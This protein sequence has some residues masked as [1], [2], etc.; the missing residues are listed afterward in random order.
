MLRAQALTLGICT[1]LIYLGY[2]LMTRQDPTSSENP[3]KSLT[4]I[5]IGLI[6][7]LIASIPLT[8]TLSRLFVESLMKIFLPAHHY[9]PPPLYSLPEKY[10]KEK[11]TEEA[12][13][14]YRKI[15][16]YHPTEL[17]A[18]LALIKIYHS[19]N[20]PQDAETML[21]QARKHISQPDAL[22]Q[23]N[24]IFHKTKPTS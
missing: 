6:I 22:Q 17:P 2:F 9:S 13:Q 3:I 14:E 4:L 21:T 20:C 11:R 18:Y 16:H 8:I 23:L 7:M 15:L 12:I 10:L 1:L 19:L 24:T 5:F